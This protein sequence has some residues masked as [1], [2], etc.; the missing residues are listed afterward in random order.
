MK[1]SKNTIAVLKNFATINSNL[2]VPEG[3]KIS[4]ISAAKD[5]MAEF[6]SE[7]EFDNELSIFNLNEFLGVLSAFNDPELELDD[8]YATISQD[9]AK[10]TYLYADK[11]H[12]TL[13]QKKITFPDAD[14]SFTL[15]NDILSKLQKMAAI[16]SVEDFA[17]ASSDGKIVL[18]V[19]DKKSPSANNFE[20]STDTDTEDNFVIDFKIDK[21]KLLSGSYEVD[22]SSKKIS[23]FT[24]A[25]LELVYYVAVEATSSYKKAD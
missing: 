16:L 25:D 4:T 22:I 14:I 23:R 10:V 24:H 6:N 17:V 13:P 12:L 7:D 15:T 20:I 1:L 21:L 19:Y 9:K 18:R 11:S 3:K 5:I 8:K 2:S